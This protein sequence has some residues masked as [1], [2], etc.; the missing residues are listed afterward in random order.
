MFHA[1]RECEPGERA[2]FLAE[3]CREDEELRS[4]VESLLASEE[5]SSALLS[6]PMR[7][8]AAMLASEQV[9]SQLAPGL[10][11][12]ALAP[13][14]TV[15]HYRIEARLGEG[16]MGV[17][18]KAKDT[19]LGRSVALKFVKAQFSRRWEREARAVAALNHPHIATLY[20]V[21]D[22][23]GS[24][25]LAME[26]VD[27]RPLKG[28]L[29][30]KRVIEYG[31][32]IADALAA[33][34][35]AGIV[36][37]DLKPGNILVTEKGSVKVLD[38]GLAKLA[39]QEGAPASTQTS[40]LAGT[41][42]YMAPEQI[43]GTPADTRSDIFAF[44]CILYELLSGRR[45]FAG[46]TITAALTAAATTEP[47]PLDGAPERLD[48]L[49]RLCL[50]K[51]PENRLQHI[52][53]ARIMLEVLREG[54]GSGRTGAAAGTGPKGRRRSRLL[55]SLA[56]TAVLLLAGVGVGFWLLRPTSHAVPKTVPLTSYPG[57]QITPAFSPDGKQVAF[58]W[59]G[60]Q[61]G[62]FDIYVKLVDA[63]EPL[64]LTS[65]P[66]PEYSPAWSPDARYIAF[67]R[68]VSDHA[69][70]WMVPALGGAER[71]LG[72]SAGC[73]GLSWSPDGKYLALM[74][75]NAPREPPSIFLL[76]VETG[77]KR[78]LTSPPIEYFRDGMPRFS[79][80]GK[81]LAFVRSPS[82]ESDEIYVLPITSDGGPLAEPRRL[83]LDERQIFGFDWTADGRRIVYSS[84]QPVS[85][86]LF[87]IPSSGGAPERLAV[88]DQYPTSLSISR[89]GS[90]LVYERDVVDPNIW[91]IPGPNSS[92]KKS[93]PTRFIASTQVDMEPQFSPDGKKIAFNSSRSGSYEIWICDGDGRNPV[94]LTSFGGPFIG[95]PRWSPDSRWIAFGNPKAGNVDI[96][97]I[98]ADGGQPRR[99]TSGASNNVRPSWSQDGRWIYFGS[100]RSGDWQIWKESAQGGTALQLT[101][102]GAREAFESLDGKSVYYAKLDAPGIWKVP[103]AGGEE[104]R[105]LDRGGQSVWALTGQGICFFDFSGSTGPALKFYNFATGKVTLLREFSKDTLLETAA[106]TLTVSPD[107]RWILYTQYDQSGSNLMLVENFR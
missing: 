87:A 29:P 61:G 2:A 23:E 26:L 107:G 76:S 62:N 78:R 47:K 20:E 37:R 63:G 100:N 106:T 83:T 44:G 40:N 5:A 19:R 10:E 27:G 34:H 58:A 89:S 36:H 6:A 18:Y 51:D 33:A 57:R 50:R 46:E 90:R 71:K 56:G 42:G 72:E 92:D 60:E 48:E 7:E 54:L 13:G 102:N 80:D 41:P 82:L 64:R 28:P 68:N 53:D 21:G 14:D 3:A 86:N 9:R 93:A 11:L 73:S 17:V 55:W 43:E 94:Q 49:V 66:A 85:T 79:P 1:A 59:D 15:A 39:E 104:T 99:I 12:A 31:I 4:E 70:I 81:A 52:D 65:N 97:V 16:G 35:A 98:S 88:A 74:D 30:V 103:V 8:A 22:H 38:F 91:R 45:A 32:Q 77:K 105:V 67:C 96:Y 75:K 25:Y 84:G 95:D 24:P 101:K 69:E